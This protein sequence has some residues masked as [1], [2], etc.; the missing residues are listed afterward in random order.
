L[1]GKTE[2]KEGTVECVDCGT[3]IDL[4]GEVKMG[5]G[6]TCPECGTVMEIV[7]L[8]PIE[9]DWIYDEPEYDPNEEEEDW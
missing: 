5:Q 8:D 7:G 2:A 1:A 3:R 6:L 4:I 9:V